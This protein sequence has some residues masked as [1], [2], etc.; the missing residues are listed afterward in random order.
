MRP[1]PFGA[2]LRCTVL[3]PIERAQGDVREVVAL[4]EQRIRAV[5]DA[6]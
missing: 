6:G 2:H 1:I 5:L 3:A 4:A